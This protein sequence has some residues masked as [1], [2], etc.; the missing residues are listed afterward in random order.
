MTAE[1]RAQIGAFVQFDRKKREQQG[2]GLGLAIARAMAKV[3]GGRM[4]L[5]AGPNDRGLKVVLDLPLAGG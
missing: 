5:E 4:T 1:Q 3:A 2:L